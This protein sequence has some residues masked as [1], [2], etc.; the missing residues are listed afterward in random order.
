MGIPLSLLA[1]AVLHLEEGDWQ[2][3]HA[4][5]QRDSSPLGAWAHGIV[6]LM[7]GDLANAQHWYQRAHRH[8]PESDAA[9]GEV[10]ALKRMLELEMHKTVT[11]KSASTERAMP[12][13]DTQ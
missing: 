3:A 11:A 9:A 13:R 10:A 6:H 12:K 8:L 2:A 4:I 1:K 5:A 7:E